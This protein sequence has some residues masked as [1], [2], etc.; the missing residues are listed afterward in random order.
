MK[1]ESS[2]RPTELFQF[3]SGQPNFVVLNDLD[4]IV[5]ITREEETI[6]QYNSYQMNTP[7]PL[8][9]VTAHAE[10]LFSL[11]KTS[12]YNRLADEIR[13]KRNKLLDESDKYMALDRVGLDTSS[14][15]AFLASLKNIFNNSMSTYRQSLRDITKQPN[16]PYEVTWPQKPE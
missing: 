10:E 15:I 2:V 13:E 9:Y 16:F 5:E 1:T 12:E 11:A 3:Y 7:A 14:A 8:S 6:Y 4:S